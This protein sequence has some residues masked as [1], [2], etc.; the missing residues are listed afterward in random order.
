[1]GENVA[2]AGQPAQRRMKPPGPLWRAE[3]AHPVLYNVVFGV[4][5]VALT[6]TYAAWWAGLPWLIGWPLL[7]GFLWRPGGYHRRKYEM[8]VAAS[9]RPVT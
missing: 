8:R 2:A 1:M 7:R 9:S 5:F 6:S 4:A 3:A